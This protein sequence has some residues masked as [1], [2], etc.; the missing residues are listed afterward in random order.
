MTTARERVQSL[1]ARLRELEQRFDNGFLNPEILPQLADNVSTDI[2]QQPRVAES[3]HGELNMNTRNAQET[4][5]VPNAAMGQTPVLSTVLD[6]AASA[7]DAITAPSANQA[8]KLP[9]NNVYSTS[10]VHLPSA[11][12]ASSSQLGA[13]ASE[14]AAPRLVGAQAVLTTANQSAATVSSLPPLPP[15]A[16][17]NT[18]TEVPLRLYRHGLP[19]RDLGP[20][21]S[22]WE[23][24]KNAAV[25]ALADRVQ[26]LERELQQQQQQGKYQPDPALPGSGQRMPEAAAAVMQPPPVDLLPVPRTVLGNTSHA[27]VAA[28]DGIHAGGAQPAPVMYYPPPPLSHPMTAD[29]ALVRLQSAQGSR[30]HARALAASVT[31]S[32][33]A[34]VP[35]VMMRNRRNENAQPRRGDEAGGRDSSVTGTVSAGVGGEGGTTTSSVGVS[36]PL[37]RASAAASAAASV[38]MVALREARPIQPAGPYPMV[39]AALA[40]GTPGTGGSTWEQAKMRALMSLEQQRDALRAQLEEFQDQEDRHRREL[41]ELRQKHQQDLKDAAGLTGRKL[42]RLMRSAWVAYS[43]RLVA[44]RTSRALHA[45]RRIT[46]RNR[47][48]AWAATVWRQK[49][50]GAAFAEW[51]FLVLINRHERQARRRAQARYHR[52]MFLAWAAAAQERRRLRRLEH[53]VLLARRRWLLAAWMQRV[54]ELQTKQRR[55]HGAKAHRLTVLLRNGWRGLAGTVTQSRVAE[56]ELRRRLA[57]T[58]VVTAFKT[59]AAQAQ[60][61]RRLDALHRRA[62]LRTVLRSWAGLAI[63]MSVLRRKLGALQK[64]WRRR[65]QAIQMAA[66][67]DAA[68]RMALLGAAGRAL[69]TAT[70]QQ[71]MA[72]ALTALRLAPREREWGHR[73]G[74]LAL[75]AWRGFMRRT[76][77]NRRVVAARRLA[78][79]QATLTAVFDAWRV[80]GKARSVKLHL[81]E[82]HRLQELE[83]MYAQQMELVRQDRAAVQGHVRAVMEELNLL[84][85]ELLR[86]FVTSSEG[87]LLGV[88]LRWRSLPP[89]LGQ[90]QPPPRCRHS[91]FYLRA[92]QLLHAPAPGAASQPLP[93][94]STMRAPFASDTGGCVGAT[95]DNTFGFGMGQG[96]YQRTALRQLRGTVAVEGHHAEVEAVIPGMAGVLVVFGGVNEDEWFRDVHILELSYSEGGNARY[97]WHQVEVDPEPES[98]GGALAATPPGT[99]A[100]G[101]TDGSAP[102]GG[103]ASSRLPLP[104]RRDHAACVI[105]PNQ[106][107]V[108]GGFDGTSEV[109]DINV[110]T[111]RAKEGNV[112]WAATV[113]TVV[114]RNRTPP[115]RSHHTVTAHESGRSLYV[116]GGYTSSRGTL[117]ELWAFHMDHLEWW[118]PNTTGDQPQPRRNHVAAMVGGRL[119]VHGGFSGMECLGDTWALDLQAWHWERLCTS[120]STPS[121]RRGHAAEVV[122]DRYLVV[123][124]GYDGASDLAGGAVLDTATGTWRD[125]SAA[126][127]PQD[128][129]TARAY[130]TLTLVGHVMVALGGSGPMGPLMDMHLLES[131]PLVAGLAQQYRLMAMAAQLSATQA[132]MADMKAALEVTRHRAEISEHQLQVLRDGSTD[133]VTRHNAA[134]ADIDRLKARL[135][136]ESVRVVAAETATAE[137]QLSLATAERRL[138]RTREGG[139][140]VAAHAQDMH[141]TVCDLREEVA[142]LRSQLL[143]TIQQQTREASQAMATASERQ[144]LQQQLAGAH[145]EAALLR[146]MLAT[147]E[148]EFRA[149]LDRQR[150]AAEAELAA[151]AEHAKQLVGAAAAAAGGA[152][153]AGTSTEMDLVVLHQLATATARAEAAELRL[154]AMERDHGGL[155]ADLANMKRQL[156]QQRQAREAAEERATAAMQHMHTSEMRYQIQLEDLQRQ[157]ADA[158][159]ER[160]RQDLQLLPPR[161]RAARQQDDEPQRTAEPAHVAVPAPTPPTEPGESTE[162]NRD[163]GDSDLEEAEQ[164]LRSARPPLQEPTERSTTTARASA[165]LDSTD[166]SAA[167]TVQYVEKPV[168]EDPTL[169]VLPEVARLLQLQR[170]L[171]GQG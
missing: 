23:A 161:K 101:A 102:R 93:V 107:V 52:T 15:P 54:G 27:H 142:R 10:T 97:H 71:L 165:L 119:Y 105:S 83:P 144:L 69:E 33:A 135:A 31:A 66:W 113:R 118:H 138:R 67:A 100:E 141:D 116:F 149:A 50:L 152:A 47:R 151:A 156:Q 111:V 121:P 35:S 170:H 59:W 24:H 42:D 117:G 78:R 58:A 40:M 79:S 129:P 85:A 74:V 94:S 55:Y 130:H 8:H 124:G 62:V 12:P 75:R 63:R 16:R 70:R 164:L 86:G 162:G 157:L 25:V 18:F 139:K 29:A 68:H 45:W 89:D 148:T 92:L 28:F 20:P 167:F 39:A 26:Q 5:A 103:L 159:R 95:L 21:Q 53:R 65:R 3:S 166:P 123:H 36:A 122:D 38:H 98:E 133:L 43:R 73:R 41:E 115:G 137:A 112:G 82:I 6:P 153:A 7:V 99:R 155:Q 163:C 48:L 60:L 64:S 104:T 158:Q 125:L 126:G 32:A 34:T 146:G 169:D 77:R 4:Y 90:W 136:A 9:R 120:G 22:V 150:A 56:M 80:L 88:P 49:D 1:D 147:A 132:G 61:G 17:P 46:T 127:G 128:M 140:E 143:S 110:V 109:M 87:G 84:R 134:L 154:H 51:H 114:P 13:A 57:R 160:W 19:H 81:R 11:E 106:F 108:V 14:V 2:V 168:L 30:G 96:T 76:I 91:T 171:L 44:L 131:P 72:H 145:Q 37:G